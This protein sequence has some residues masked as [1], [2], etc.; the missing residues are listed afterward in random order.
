MSSQP[1][2]K[3][4]NNQ[5]LTPERL[6]LLDRLA[7]VYVQLPPEGRRELERFVQADPEEQERMLEQMRREIADGK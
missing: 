2:S 3:P 7:A 1:T 4:I 6:A 5:P